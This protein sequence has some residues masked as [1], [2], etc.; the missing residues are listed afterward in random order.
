MHLLRTLLREPELAM[1]AG[2]AVVLAGWL[3]LTIYVL[4]LGVCP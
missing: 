2:A 4:T 1:A 3:V